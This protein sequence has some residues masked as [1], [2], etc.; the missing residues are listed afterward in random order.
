[1]QISNS[2][3]TK[4]VGP[5]LLFAVITTMP[6]YTT[7]ASLFWATAFLALIGIVGAVVAIL[8]LVTSIPKR[9]ILCNIIS[10]SQMV[11]GLPGL[12]GDLDIS[13]KKNKL[14]DPQVV[15]I[16]ISNVGKDPILRDDFTENRWLEFRLTTRQSSQCCRQSMSLILHP[17]QLC[18]LA[19]I[20]SSSDQSYLS[21][22][23]SLGYLCLLKG[24]RGKHGF[25]LTPSGRSTCK[26]VIVQHGS[27][28][29]SSVARSYLQSVLA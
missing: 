12:N 3:G 4:E 1:V 29:D 27:D 7:A 26:S 9:K 18:P 19:N 20:Y 25:L 28:R 21:G 5:G 6:W 14:E 16:E 2:G 8:T 11:S 24:G 17:G 15:A 22:M 10:R 23:R 13:Y